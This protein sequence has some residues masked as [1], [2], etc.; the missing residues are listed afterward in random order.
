MVLRSFQSVLRLR[1]IEMNGA[2]N[3][4]GRGKAIIIDSTKN[5]NSYCWNALGN[6]FRHGVGF[7]K[8]ITKAKEFYRKVIDSENGIQGIAA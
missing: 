6:C 1:S 4:V 5:G 2:E 8:G 3:D 7:G